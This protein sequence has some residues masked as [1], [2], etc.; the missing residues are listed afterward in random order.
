MNHITCNIISS[1]INV[2]YNHILS[3]CQ[4]FFGNNYEIIMGG[5][6]VLLKMMGN[7]G[8]EMCKKSV[9]EWIENMGRS[10]CRQGQIPPSLLCCKLDAPLLA[11]GYL[12]FASNGPSAVLAAGY[13]TR[14]VRDHS[15]K[16]SQRKKVS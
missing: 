10:E 15:K 12:T 2:D 13:L 8:E 9:D 14:Y 11:Q 5:E 4:L 16:R 6:D 1:L 7:V 3:I